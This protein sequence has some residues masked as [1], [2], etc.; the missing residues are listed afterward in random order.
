[1]K[2]NLTRPC[3]NCPFL[4]KPQHQ[5]W[6]GEERAQDII[7]GIV[8]GQGTFICHKTDQRM[9]RNQEEQHCAGALIMLERMDRPNQMMRIAG[10]INQYDP[11]RLHMD[12][13]NVVQDGDEFIELHTRL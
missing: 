9:Q 7:E 5:G 13:P 4:A 12:T 11:S 10:R 2:F 1:M 3:A 8:D 6:L